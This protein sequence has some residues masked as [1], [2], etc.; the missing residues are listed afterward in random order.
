M[1]DD[2][3]REQSLSKKHKETLTLYINQVPLIDTTMAAALI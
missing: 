2:N 3:D 1:I